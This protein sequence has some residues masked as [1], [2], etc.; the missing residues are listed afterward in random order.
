MPHNQDVFN[1]DVPLGTDLHQRISM[2][3]VVGHQCR[4]SAPWDDDVLSLEPNQEY[5]PS[6]TIVTLRCKRGFEPSTPAIQC[7]RQ[8][9][10]NRWNETDVACIEQCRK[11][12][13]QA[14]ILLFKPD[15]EFYSRNTVV[16]LSCRNF[17]E[18]P[19]THVIECER[20][21]FYNSWNVTN[22]TC[23][24]M[25]TR[26]LDL[27]IRTILKPDQQYYS[28]G[29]RV[30]V[31]CFKGFHLYVWHGENYLE[32]QN[33]SDTWSSYNFVCLEIPQ[34]TIS[35]LNV[36]SRSILVSWNYTRNLA[37]V[38]LNLTV[39][40]EKVL[41]YK[42]GCGGQL[43]SEASTRPGPE[44][45]LSTCQDLQPFT[46]YIV[47]FYAAYVKLNDP[48]ETITAKRLP[49]NTS[50]EGATPNCV[51]I[52]TCSAKI[53]KRSGNHFRCPGWAQEAPDC[54]LKQQS[55]TQYGAESIEETPLKARAQPGN[56]Q[57]DIP[58]NKLL[59]YIVQM[60]ELELKNQDEEATV[61]FALEYKNL[62][63]DLQY[64]HFIASLPDNK[65]KNRY[66]NSIPYDHSR[67]VLDPSDS[68]E[69]DY[70]NASYID[71]YENPSSY[72]ATQGPLSQTAAD[73]WR[74]VWQENSSVIVMLTG[75]VEQEKVKCEQYWPEQ[76]ETYQGITVRLCDVQQTPQ[77][78]VRT[79]ELEARGSAEKR[80][81]S[82]FHYLPWPDHGLPKAPIGLVRFILQV[83][84]STSVEAGPVVVHCSAGIGRTGTFIAL[85][86]LLE[87]AKAEGKVNVFQCVRKMRKKRVNMVQTQGQYE[88]LYDA[89]LEALLCEDTGISAQNI[90]LHIQGLEEV[91]SAELSG[92]ARE[93]QK[94]EHFC[95]VYHPQECR[96]ALKPA[97]K[98]KNRNLNILPAEDV[99]TTLMSLTNS[100]GLPAYINAIFLSV[101]TRDESRKSRRLESYPVFWPESGESQYG[102]FHVKLNSETGAAGFTVRTL[103]LTN[104]KNKSRPGLQIKLLQLDSWPMQEPVPESPRVILSMLEEVESRQQAE[105]DSHTLVTCWDGA[106]RCGLFCAASVVCEQIREEGLVDVFQA[107][108]TIRR[109][110]PQLLRD[111]Q[112]YRFCYE[113]AKTQ[114]DG[115]VDSTSNEL[116]Q[117]E[118]KRRLFT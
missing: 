21:A 100:D 16:T 31:S 11:T 99:R 107:V 43:S 8:D 37:I 111:P 79:L 74:M 115:V 5:Y 10:Y 102:P 113:V 86:Y 81:V 97:N 27:P 1:R 60:R 34:I 71:G 94:L 88:F 6:N 103:T 45:H 73:F 51:H 40:C 67:V 118:E 110:R 108:K 53:P 22:I 93:F 62:P 106:S 65:L 75:L 66:S 83:N 61:G 77:V 26:P 44:G 87:M 41:Q 114:L 33:N 70:I 46:S 76:M 9:S 96:E 85:G 38:P 24:E 91:D 39:R 50:E 92:Y 19:S 72:I 58:V 64:D 52:A 117:G 57:T 80:T 84:Q 25:C 54:T 18:K 89:L 15:Q 42:S 7:N 29:S 98:P 47:L 30:E 109:S 78:I 23:N 17:L 82:H 69:G 95:T 59:D 63:H 36:S 3:Q 4:R 68:S 12:D 55:K 32:C 101:R 49:V 20:R 104:T 35:R 116:P 105:E 56:F 112:Q 14:G 48:F 90:Q 2:L 28:R 13:S